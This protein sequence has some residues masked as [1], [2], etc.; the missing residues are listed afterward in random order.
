MSN[1]TQHISCFQDSN[2]VEI[3]QLITEANEF[4]GESNCDTHDHNSQTVDLKDEFIRIACA[5][6]LKVDWRNRSKMIQQ[7]TIQNP[8]CKRSVAKERFRKRF[9]R[10]LRIRGIGFDFSK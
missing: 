7:E 5:H 4:N 1:E 2:I 3:D 9:E 10:A 6:G 8:I